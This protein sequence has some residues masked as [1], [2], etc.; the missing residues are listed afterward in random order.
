[1]FDQNKRNFKVPTSLANCLL[2]SSLSLSQNVLIFFLA[3]LLFC[4]FFHFQKE[5]WSLLKDTVITT[6]NFGM[7]MMSSLVNST[8]PPGE[9]SRECDYNVAF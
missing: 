4:C 1:M 5:A 8:W 9:I 7:K 3:L 6:W 2:N